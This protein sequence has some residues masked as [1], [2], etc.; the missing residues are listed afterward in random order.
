MAGAILRFTNVINGTICADFVTKTMN[1]NAINTSPSSDQT[2]DVETAGSFTAK[3]SSRIY[4]VYVRRDDFF[5]IV[6]AEGLSAN[7]QTLTVHLGL[8]GFLIGAMM[9]K[10]A[11][12]KK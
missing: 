1:Y 10:R 6:L 7:P 9:K 5:F 12:K 4:R 3:L 8:L 11:K 2:N